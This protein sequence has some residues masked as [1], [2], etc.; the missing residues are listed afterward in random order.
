MVKCSAA[1][2]LGCCVGDGLRH[3]Q[4]ADR[5]DSPGPCMTER[6][7]C[8]S[9][10]PAG[11]AALGEYQAH[12]LQILVADVPGVLQQVRTHT[13]TQLSNTVL[14][15]VQRPPSPPALQQSQVIVCVLRCVPYVLV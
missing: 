12:T 5:A 9:V 1:V 7:S 8:V 2:A 10:P 14:V 4:Y 15:L 11:A 6:V 13:H 3:A